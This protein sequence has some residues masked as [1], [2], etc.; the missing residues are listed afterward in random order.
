MGAETNII[1]QPKNAL[2]PNKK[3][4]AVFRT[5]EWPQ[6]YQDTYKFK[7]FKLCNYS[8]ENAMSLIAKYE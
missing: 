6:E 8:K 4:L 5:L 2:N 3:C 7:T 1:S